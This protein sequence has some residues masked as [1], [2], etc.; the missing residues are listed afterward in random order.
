MGLRALVWLCA[1]RYGNVRGPRR[2]TG[3]TNTEYVTARTIILP[4]PKLPE[5]DTA[6]E[7]MAVES[8][9]NPLPSI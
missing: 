9:S 2:G 5:G 6:S 7:Q 3:E 1:D 8:F 4:I